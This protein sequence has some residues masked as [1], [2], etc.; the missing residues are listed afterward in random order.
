VIDFR[1]VRIGDEVLLRATVT[2]VDI[3]D[4]EY[5]IRTDYTFWPEKILVVGHTPRAIEADDLVTWP[6]DTQEYRVVAVDD[7]MAWIRS[8]RNGNSHIVVEV[9][10][11]ERKP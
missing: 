9:E 1:K 11:L 7:G 10:H 8:T 3:S 2:A 6:P 4:R 5:P